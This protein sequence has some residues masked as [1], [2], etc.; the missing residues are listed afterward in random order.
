MKKYAP[1]YDLAA[2]LKEDC[3]SFII[4]DDSIKIRILTEERGDDDLRCEFPKRS[5]WCFSQKYMIN[6]GRPKYHI[7]ISTFLSLPSPIFALTCA[8]TVMFGLVWFNPLKCF[9]GSKGHV[10]LDRNPGRGY[11]ALLL[12]MIP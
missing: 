11:D 5:V 1:P 2:I 6:T 12:R 8:V 4:R 10:A 9:F 7:E 3:K